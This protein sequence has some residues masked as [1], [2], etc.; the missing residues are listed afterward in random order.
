[1]HKISNTIKLCLLIETEFN[2]VAYTPKRSAYPFANLNFFAEIK[3]QKL[4][5][6]S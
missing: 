2:N 6:L 5:L 4:S 3:I 1:M